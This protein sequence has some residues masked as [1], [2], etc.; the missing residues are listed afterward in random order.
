MVKQEVSSKEITA[1]LCIRKA[2][3]VLEE[4]T[5]PNKYLRAIGKPLAKAIATITTAC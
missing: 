1:L 3:K 5:I 2:N 4:D